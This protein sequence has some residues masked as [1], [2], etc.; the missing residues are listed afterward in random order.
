MTRRAVA[1]IACLMLAGMIMSDVVA[2][3]PNPYD[4]P[5]LL[6]LGSG[7]APVGGFCGAPAIMPGK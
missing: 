6:A 2:A 3:P 5:A 1:A 4:A 7:A